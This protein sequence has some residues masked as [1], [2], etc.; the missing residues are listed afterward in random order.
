M[1]ILI[2]IMQQYIIYHCQSSHFVDTTISCWTLPKSYS[3]VVES[4]CISLCT[5]PNSNCVYNYQRVKPGV[6]PQLAFKNC[7]SVHTC[8]YILLP[9]C[10]YVSKP[11][12]GKSSSYTRN[13]GWTQP[14]SHLC[15]DRLWLKIVSFAELKTRHGDSINFEIGFPSGHFIL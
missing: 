3:I 9:F 11:S 14:V 15:T 7:L 10:N 8:L 5:S 12:S 4:S 1:K 2:K 13:K 6:L